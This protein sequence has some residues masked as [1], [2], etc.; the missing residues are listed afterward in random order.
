MSLCVQA[1]RILED[2]DPVSVYVAIA[3][4]TA[5]EESSISLIAGQCVE[6]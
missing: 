6:V 2:F 3:D 1:V 5:V 4:F